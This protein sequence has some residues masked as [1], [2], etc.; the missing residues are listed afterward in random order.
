MEVFRKKIFCC[1]VNGCLKE[2]TSKYN[3]LRHISI[4]HLKTKVGNCEICGKEFISKDNLKEHRFIHLNVKPF[5]CDLCE[6]TFRNKCMMTRHKRSHLFESNQI[7]DIFLKDKA[8]NY[9]ISESF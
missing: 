5:S 7:T 1:Y 3:L 6:K 8:F 9:L 2:Y 4:N